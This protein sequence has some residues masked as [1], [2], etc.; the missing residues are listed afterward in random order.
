MPPLLCYVP[1]VFGVWNLFELLPQKMRMKIA[2]NISDFKNKNWHPGLSEPA[3]AHWGTDLVQYQGFVVGPV[4]S[5]ADCVH[6]NVSIF[7]LFSVLMGESGFT[8]SQ[9]SFSVLTVVYVFLL[10]V[11][12]FLFFSMYTYCC[13]RILRRGYLDWGFSVL[14]PR[15]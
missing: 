7:N 3:K 14:F 9:Y 15:L 10:F 11:H 1:A 5:P 2:P 12:V 8:M 4:S 6:W 13:L